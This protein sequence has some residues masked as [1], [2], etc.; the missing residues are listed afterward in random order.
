[1]NIKTWAEKVQQAAGQP[2]KVFMLGLIIAAFCTLSHV[3]FLS[4]I[5]RDTAHVYAVFARA[6]GEGNWSEGI[7]T[8]VPMLNISLAGILAGCGLEAVKALSL[9]AGIFYLLTCFPLRR[10][11]ERYV[12]PAAAAWGC[13]LYVCAPKMIRF[14]CAPLLESTRIFFLVAAI[15]YF[16]RCSEEPKLKNMVLFGLSAGFLAVSRAEGAVVSLALLGGYWLFL[17]LFRKSAVWKKQFTAMII[18]V[19]CA[20]AAIS[21]FCAMNY[22]KSG[23]FT[24]DARM[25]DFAKLQIQKFTGDST[26]AVADAQKKS[27]KSTSYSNDMT[28]KKGFDHDVS[29]FI[30][31][32][33]ELY[34]ILALLGM[35]LIIKRKQWS[36]DYWLLVAVSAL[37]CVVYIATISAQRYY[38][39]LIPLFMMF[40]LAG[41]AFVRDLI[42]KHLPQKLHIFCLAVCV[43][44]L[45]GQVANGVKRAYSSKG[46]DLQAAGRWIAEYGK[47]HFPDRKLIIFAP[48]MT[49][50]AYWSGAVH[51]DGY[52]KKQNDPATFKDF[53]L[54]VVHRKKSF[55]ME[56][57]TDLERLSDTPHSKNIW[58]FKV[59]KQENK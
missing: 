21:P 49:E 15:L 42:K 58:I 16:L 30:R 41:V 28:E 45:G 25:V 33:Y 4:D 9:V 1:M 38:L 46:K 52:E 29:C 39:F 59:K 8:K 32:G 17:L 18:A 51:T 24:P 19:I 5:F 54:A 53:D 56:K 44:I 31:G 12:S 23:Y 48:Q 10:L 36:T 27:E 2:E 14:A 3:F 50:V 20:V 37:Q 35:I 57:R 13:V 7:A 26:C 43:L 55:N 6:I 47:K 11:L 40:T 34:I 22:S